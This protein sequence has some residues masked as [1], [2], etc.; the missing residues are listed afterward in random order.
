M[1]KS[2]RIKTKEDHKQALD[3]LVTLMSKDPEAGSS[4]FAEFDALA[5][6]IE[7]YEKEH[8]PMD[9]PDPIEAIEFRIE[10]QGST[11]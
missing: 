10:Q 2:K 8:F 4:E 7:I 5:A 1:N 6:L 3:R 9:K 11:V